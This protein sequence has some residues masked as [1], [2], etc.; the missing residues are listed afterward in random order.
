MP[1]RPVRIST[2]TASSTDCDLNIW[3]ANV[4]ITSGASVVQG[5]ADGDGDVDGDDFLFWQRNAGHPMP[6]TGAGSG[7][8]SG[9]QCRCSRAHR[10]CPVAH[11]ADSFSLAFRRRRCGQVALLPRLRVAIRG[12]DRKLRG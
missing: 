3:L 5:D 6:W 9:T 7:S 4:G 8:G 11:P 12:V 1:L 10:N 2:V